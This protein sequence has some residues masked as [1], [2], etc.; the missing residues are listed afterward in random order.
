MRPLEVAVVDLDEPGYL[1]V[2]EVR[3]L[4]V[5]VFEDLDSLLFAEVCR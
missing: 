5:L 2:A 4:G 1:L 3:E